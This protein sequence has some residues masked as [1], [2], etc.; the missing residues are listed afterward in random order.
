MSE[1]LII[2]GKASVKTPKKRQCLS[3]MLKNY[4]SRKRDVA[5][6]WAEE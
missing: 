4:L 1:Q 2:L 5:K 3:L 6:G